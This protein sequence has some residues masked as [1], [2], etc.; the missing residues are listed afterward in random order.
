MRK[1]GLISD[2]HGFL[3]PDIVKFLENVDEIWHTGDIGSIEVIETIQ[4]TKPLKAVYGNIDNMQ[5]RLLFPK[6][7]MFSVEDVKVF[8]IHIGGYPGHYEKNIKEM[9]KESHAKIFIAGHSHILKVIPDKELKLLHLNP[10]AAGKSGIHQLQTAMRFEI[11][12]ADIR[13][14]EIYEKPRH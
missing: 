5:I 14:L 3:D 13:N 12:G 11:E 10:G 7:Q 2:T 9:L 6:V 1:L 4:L 8:M